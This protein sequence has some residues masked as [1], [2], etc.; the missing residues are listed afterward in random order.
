MFEIE[1]LKS[2]SHYK[3]KNKKPAK[4]QRNHKPAGG[5]ICIRIIWVWAWGA[6]CGM[7]WICWPAAAAAAATPGGG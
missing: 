3:S 6:G 2:G 4:P 1:N 5:T 7:Y